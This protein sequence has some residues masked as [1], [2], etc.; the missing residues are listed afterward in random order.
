MR[1]NHQVV[2]L[3]AVALAVLMV[4]FP[5]W[6]GGPFDRVEYALLFA[7]PEPPVETGH[8]QP[9][10][11]DIERLA[12]QFVLLAVATVG[13]LFTRRREEEA[14]PQ[15][16]HISEADRDRLDAMQVLVT[17]E[18]KALEREEEHWITI[19]GVPCRLFRPDAEGAE[20]PVTDPSDAAGVRIDG[21]QDLVDVQ[22]VRD[23]LGFEGKIQRQ[24]MQWV[25][26]K[27][28]PAGAGL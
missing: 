15:M 21:R 13:M 16:T 3:G 8:F 26:M 14:L 1:D 20:E 10:T 18:R 7:P 2:I 23:S 17:R 24:N 19:A 22:R 27:D 25:V 6:H 9:Y 11:L 4:L 12:L 5:P 28:N